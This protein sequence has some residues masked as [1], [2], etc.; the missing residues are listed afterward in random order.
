[1]RPWRGECDVD[2][3]FTSETTLLITGTCNIAH[4]GRTTVIAHQTIQPGP[5]GIVYSNTAIYRAA[6]GDELR[7]T[8][9]GVATPTATGLSLSGI[10]TAVGG[11]G[12]FVNA[13]GSA[14]LEGAVRFTGPSSTTGSYEL[15]GHIEY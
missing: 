10:E 5:S 15:S 1:M 9:V 11:T 2:A 8:D 12:R 7:T 13:R 4:L 3:V 14:T 6:N